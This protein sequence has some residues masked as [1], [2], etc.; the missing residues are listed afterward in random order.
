M[1]YVNLF[2]FYVRTWAMG[3]KN[4]PVAECLVSSLTLYGIPFG[5]QALSA[6]YNVRVHPAYQGQ[7]WPFEAR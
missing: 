4:C 2:S 7:G 5:R 1:K 3:E 6:L